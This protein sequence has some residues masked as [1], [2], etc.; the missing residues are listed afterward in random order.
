MVGR[1]PGVPRQDDRTAG[2]EADRLVRL[3]D[4][5]GRPAA[6]AAGAVATA[7]GRAG[8][9]TND[10]PRGFTEILFAYAS[11]M[12][13]NGQTMAGLNANSLFYNLTTTSPWWRAASASPRWPVL[14]GRLGGKAQEAGDGRHAALRHPDLRRAF[15]W[16]PC[17][18]SRRCPSCRR[19]RSDRSSRHSRRSVVC[20]RRTLRQR[21]EEPA[22]DSR[23]GHGGA[24]LTPAPAQAGLAGA[25]SVPGGSR[26][27]PRTGSRL[28]TRARGLERGPRSGHPQSS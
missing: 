7:A 6:A 24:L 14:A 10:G 26:S 27:F 11:C 28:P 17:C 25:R 19:W 12:A 9:A 23:N 2:G 16:P 15:R 18:W 20:A 13:N 1:T 4:A 8:L 21:H 22:A 5:A 3:A